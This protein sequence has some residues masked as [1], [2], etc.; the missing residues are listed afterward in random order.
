MK[1]HSGGL[2]EINGQLVAPVKSI[3]CYIFH[4]CEQLLICQKV[5]EQIEN[6]CYDKSLPSLDIS[7]KDVYNSV[8]KAEYRKL[9][10]ENYLLQNLSFDSQIETLY[11]D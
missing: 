5:V 9:E 3:L 7:I 6:W 8:V 2:K 1:G 4:H 11:T 10:I